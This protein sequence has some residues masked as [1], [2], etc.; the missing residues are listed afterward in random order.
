MVFGCGFGCRSASAALTV[1]SLFVMEGSDV[2]SVAPAF[3]LA[4]VLVRFGTGALFAV[5]AVAILF[6]LPRLRLS[7]RD[8]FF[9]VSSFICSALSLSTVG[10]AP[11]RLRFSFSDNSSVVA[12]FE[13]AAPSS[14]PGTFAGVADRF[15]FCVTTGCYVDEGRWYSSITMSTIDAQYGTNET[16]YVPF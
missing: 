10:F 2:S 1:S 15:L 9:T 12:S 5:L 13:N 8:P 7:F 4:K 3:L 14:S 16:N 11:L 6:P